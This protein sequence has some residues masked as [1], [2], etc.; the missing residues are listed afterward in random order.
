[1]QQA[2]TVMCFLRNVHEFKYKM[3]SLF[4]CYVFHSKKNTV[5]KYGH[6]HTC[7]MDP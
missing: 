5:I 7:I 1:M 4:V 6:R 2:F 3:F